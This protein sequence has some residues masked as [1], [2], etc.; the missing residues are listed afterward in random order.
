MVRDKLDG[1][2]LTAVIRTY[3]DI[4]HNLIKRTKYTRVFLPGYKVF[5]KTYPLDKLLPKI[6]VEALI[7]VW[8][9]KTGTTQLANI[10]SI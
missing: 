5:D 2:A 7:T 6:N 1:E 4:T 9:T 10:K 3:G 8:Q